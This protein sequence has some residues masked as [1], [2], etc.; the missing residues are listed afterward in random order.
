[1][2]DNEIKSQV[3]AF[4]AL[5]RAERREAYA[6]LPV[7]VQ[8]KARKVIEARRGISHRADGGDIVLTKETYISEILRVQGRVDELPAKEAALKSKLASLKSGLQENWGDDALGEA[9]TA[10]EQRV[11][12]DNA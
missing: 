11:V 9:E 2:A 12:A 1:M 10:L 4:V 7:E 6:A 8:R 5:P 3:D